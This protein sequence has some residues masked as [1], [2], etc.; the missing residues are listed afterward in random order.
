MTPQGRLQTIALH[1]Q[2]VSFCWV[3][4]ETANPAKRDYE[5]RYIVPYLKK[6]I[7]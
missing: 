5:Y 2:R 1:N 7:S 6:V 3:R 4:A